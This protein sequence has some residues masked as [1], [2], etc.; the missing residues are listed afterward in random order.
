MAAKPVSSNPRHETTWT[1]YA[2]VMG[3]FL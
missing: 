2:G 3:R 1:P